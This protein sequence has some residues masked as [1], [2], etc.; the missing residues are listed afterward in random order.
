MTDLLLSFIGAS[1]LF[2]SLVHYEIKRT[3]E[4]KKQ[5]DA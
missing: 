4:D 3:R 2:F 1:A 5:T